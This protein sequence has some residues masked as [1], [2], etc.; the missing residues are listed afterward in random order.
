MRRSLFLLREDDV[1]VLFS[2][3]YDNAHKSPTLS[4]EENMQ[5]FLLELQICNGFCFFK[6]L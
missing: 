6:Y 4:T 2:N 3:P 5:L 1:T